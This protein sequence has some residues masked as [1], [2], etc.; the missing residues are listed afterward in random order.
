MKSVAFMPRK[1]T[2]TRAEFRDYYET[3]HFPLAMRHFPFRKY[4]RSHL[5]EPDAVSSFDCY[6]EFWVDDFAPV[7]ALL[8]GPVGR[9]MREDEHNFTDQPRIASALA[10]EFLLCG[11]GRFTEEDGVA[12]TLHLLR[13]PEISSAHDALRQCISVWDREL[14]LRATL[15]FLRP[16]WPGVVLQ[17][18][19]VLSV[20][21]SDSSGAGSLALPLVPDRWTCLATVQ[22]RTQ[23]NAQPMKQHG[24]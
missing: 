8:A 13:L 5:C 6:S 3:R 12:R 18:N 4:V 20:W 19:A 15:D 14:F 10:E 24:S 1:P 11:E 17:A 2:L 7:R 16:F 21:P 23:E 22:C 9:I